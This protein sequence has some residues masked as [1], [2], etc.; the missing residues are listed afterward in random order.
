MRPLRRP[1]R[2]Q[3]RNH[4][5]VAGAP[6]SR[7]AAAI[8]ILTARIGAA[9][10]GGLRFVATSRVTA[11]SRS[12]RRAFGTPRA[13]VDNVEVIEVREGA[14]RVC[15]R[16]WDQALTARVGQSIVCG[17]PNSGEGC[18]ARRGVQAA[19]TAV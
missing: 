19:R 16:V 13:T 15:E 4:A 10:V 14:K 2:H 8:V 3:T 5:V 9:A 11:C 17:A 18:S 1:A 7:T 12:R 6:I